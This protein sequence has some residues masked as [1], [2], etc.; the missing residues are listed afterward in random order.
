MNRNDIDRE[1]KE[2]ELLVAMVPMESM[3]WTDQ[4]SVAAAYADLVERIKPIFAKYALM[5]PEVTKFLKGEE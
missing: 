1:L 3:S 5:N 4:I 2:F